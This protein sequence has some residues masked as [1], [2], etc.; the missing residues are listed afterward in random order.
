MRWVFLV[1]VLLIVPVNAYGQAKENRSLIKPTPGQLMPLLVLS[2]NCPVQIP[3]V[4]KLVRG[5]LIRSRVKPLD[6]WDD[7][8][9]MTV[10]VMCTEQVRRTDLVAFSVI[11]YFAKPAFHTVGGDLAGVERF[12]FADRLLD[13]WGVGLSDGQGGKDYMLKVVRNTTER[14]VTDF[15]AANFDL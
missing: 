13:Y 10:N 2:P 4:D 3:D 9:Y 12:V 1:G 5:I 6:S 15:M 14:A 8:L 11:V 7:E